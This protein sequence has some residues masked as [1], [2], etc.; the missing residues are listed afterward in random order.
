MKKTI[1]FNSE[2]VR[3]MP[4]QCSAIHFRCEGLLCQSGLSHEGFK[5]DPT[6]FSNGWN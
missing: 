1:K 5:K 4:P 2:G 6:D 3:Y